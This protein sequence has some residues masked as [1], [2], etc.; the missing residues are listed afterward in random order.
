VIA[1]ATV[2]FTQQ[3][4]RADATAATDAAENDIYAALLGVSR[5]VDR[6]MGASRWRPAFVPYDET[7]TYRVTG[8]EVNSAENTFALPDPLLALSGVV[9]GTETLTVDTHVEVYPDTNDT[10]YHELRLM[11]WSRLWYDYPTT[12]YAP[13]TVQITG[14]WGRHPDYS[15]AWQAVDTVQDTPLLSSATTL[16]VVDVDGVDEEGRTPR[17]GRGDLLRI[18][19]EYLAVT[20]TDTSANTA[21]VRRGVFGSTAAEHALNTD[22]EVWRVDEPLRRAVA[23]QA[24]FQVARQGSYTTTEI[25]AMGAE[26]RYPN[27]LLPELRNVLRGYQWER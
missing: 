25:S 7:R 17:I 15:N 18:D 12:D 23:R 8:A 5:R 1:Y 24:A 2:A 20:D 13:L 22:V 26:V 3:I 16:T 27:D 10:P 9:L 6:I 14:T 21:T 11:N 4:M 19:T